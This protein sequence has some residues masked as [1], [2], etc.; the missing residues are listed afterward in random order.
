MNAT[1]KEEKDDFMKQELQDG[2]SLDCNQ[3]FDNNHLAISSKISNIVSNMKDDLKHWKNVAN[4]L[5][6]ICAYRGSNGDWSFP[7]FAKEDTE[8]ATCMTIFFEN[9]TEDQKNE[10]FA[11][12]QSK[13]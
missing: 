10:V 4:D 13:S 12:I 3:D 6:N 1:T 9:A 8:K 5:N 11:F 2:V 7:D